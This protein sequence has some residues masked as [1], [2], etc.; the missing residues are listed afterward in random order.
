[1]YNDFSLLQINFSHSIFSIRIL[2][3]QGEGDI[4]PKI[5]E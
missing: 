5:S 4:V 1:M 2:H 3:L